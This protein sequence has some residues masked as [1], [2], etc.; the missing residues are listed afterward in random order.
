LNLTLCSRE[1]PLPF[2]GGAKE[3]GQGTGRGTR[4]VRQQQIEA[5]RGDPQAGHRHGEGDQEQGANQHE[6]AA[7]K[8]EG[9]AMIEHTTRNDTARRG[10]GPPPTATSTAGGQCNVQ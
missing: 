10:G 7:R 3:V 8:R 4:H 2:G 9:A 1:A 5:C 6:K